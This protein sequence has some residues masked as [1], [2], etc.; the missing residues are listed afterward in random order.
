[1]TLRGILLPVADKHRPNTEPLVRSVE[2]FV[3]PVS[4]PQHSR[5]WIPEVGRRALKW[6]RTCGETCNKIVVQFE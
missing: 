4:V 6:V 3:R 5:N 2:A 1:M